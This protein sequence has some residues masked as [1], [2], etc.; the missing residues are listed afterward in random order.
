MAQSSDLARALE[1]AA[2]EG[3][4]SAAE[5]CMNL[6]AD[7]AE[8]VGASGASGEKALE[9]AVR[10]R[11]WSAAAY[12]ADFLAQ[13]SAAGPRR[14]G[15][16]EE[17]LRPAGAYPPAIACPPAIAL[18]AVC[19]LAAVL[20]FALARAYFCAPRGRL[21]GYWATPGGDLFEIRG[22]RVA[23]A[24]GVLGAEPG[25]AYTLRRTGC[26][27]VLAAFPRGE[28]RGRVGLDRRKI[29]WDGGEPPWRRQGVAQK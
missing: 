12:L 9:A 2:A 5:A 15:G 22:G 20:I 11:Q 27:E 28:L 14:G 1:A 10:A 8:G 17:L 24:A 26:R 3:R 18:A 29:L 16:A 25:A 6:L 19:A 7:R 4:T 21:E 23:T 13:T